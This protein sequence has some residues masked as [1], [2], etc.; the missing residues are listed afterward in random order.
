MS[1]FRHLPDDII[2]ID[3]EKFDLELFLEVEPEYSI[4][5]DAISREYDGNRHIIFTKNNLFV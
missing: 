1:I 2:E 5:E 4:P 3:G